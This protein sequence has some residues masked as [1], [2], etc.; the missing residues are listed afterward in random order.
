MA[1]LNGNDAV[2]Q[3]NSVDFHDVWVD[4]ASHDFITSLE[5]ITA[6]AG[7]DYKSFAAKLKEL[8]FSCSVAWD[9]T[10]YGT[11]DSDMEPGQESTLIY[12]PE[13]STTGKPKLEGTAILE[14]VNMQGQSVDKTKVFFALSFKFT[15]TPTT[16]LTGTDLGVYP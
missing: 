14:S 3:W 9:V 10:T 5:E 12:G 8:S 2:I 15:G 13:G 1:Q 6:G 4:S 16:T 7:T 11:Y